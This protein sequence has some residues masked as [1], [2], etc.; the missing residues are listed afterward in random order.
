MKYVLNLFENEFENK[1]LILSFQYQLLTSEL[2]RSPSAAVGNL[3]LS[4][5]VKR[6][7]HKRSREG[8]PL[9]QQTNSQQINTVTANEDRTYQIRSGL[10]DKLAAH[11]PD[12]YTHPRGSLIDLIP[13]SAS[14]SNE[15]SLATQ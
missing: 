1:V 6:A 15:N 2:F 7:S 3:M 10:F 12:E 8:S 5:T 9:H 4:S 11:F 14:L 13:Y